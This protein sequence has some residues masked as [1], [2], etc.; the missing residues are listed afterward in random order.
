MRKQGRAPA[1]AHG[2]VDLHL[3]RRTRGLAEKGFKTLRGDMLIC[4]TNFE[5]SIQ[6]SWYGS[7][8]F[9]ILRTFIYSIQTEVKQLVPSECG[10]P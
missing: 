6:I 9:E 3:S 2:E 1:R 8:Y 4:Q 10:R 5:N 7:I